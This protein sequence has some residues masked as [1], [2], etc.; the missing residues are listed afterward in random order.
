MEIEEEVFRVNQYS[1]QGIAVIT[2]GG[3]SQGK[4]YNFQL[5]TD[6]KYLLVTKDL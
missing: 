5:R 4:F 1:G 3:D 6:L 2:S